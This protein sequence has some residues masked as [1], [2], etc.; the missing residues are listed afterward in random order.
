MINSSGIPNASNGGPH[1][2]TD[3]VGPS[4]KVPGGRRDRESRAIDFVRKIESLD[5][6]ELL[7]RLRGV[8]VKER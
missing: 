4:P 7:H 3:V 2:L 5:D 6:Q 8:V 1:Q